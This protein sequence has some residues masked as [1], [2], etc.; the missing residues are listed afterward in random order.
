[1]WIRCP[2]CGK[3]TRAAFNIALGVNCV[4]CGLYTSLEKASR[5]GAT[6]QE[7]FQT[8]LG[9]ARVHRVDLASAYSVLMGIIPYSKA[10]S[11][12]GS[13]E[14]D[15]G[16]RDAVERGFLTPSEAFS[17]GDR[18]LYATTL[19]LNHSLDM[20]TAFLITDN[21]MQLAE[22]LR[23][24]IE[25]DP[26]ELEERPETRTVWSAVRTAGAFAT[27]AVL[28]L[29]MFP[30]RHSPIANANVPPRPSTSP[31]AAPGAGA[32]AEASTPAPQPSGAR[33]RLDDEGRVTEVS[34]PNPKVVL[35][36]LCA[37]EQ[38]VHNLSPIALAP[39][40]PA[41]AGTRLGL[42]R[43]MRDLSGPRCVAIR[44]DPSSGRWVVGDGERPIETLAAPD[45]PPESIIT[46]M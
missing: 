40:V 6:P 4:S 33:F 7:R 37:H 26:A 8:A 20:K 27:V 5:L 21:R 16:F 41:S 36:E 46:P 39:A 43:D 25:P 28:M 32:S 12:P 45:L 22:A 24:I 30:S 2:R 23:G 15:P 1:M 13:F 34:G 42:L 11:I 10:L 44:R 14:Y 35:S 31:D 3:S 19:A 18:P 38:F 29:T 17:R 9:F